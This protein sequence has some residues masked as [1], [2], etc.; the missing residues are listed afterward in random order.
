MKDFFY[1]FFFSFGQLFVWMAELH[2]ACCVSGG[3][4]S[5]R[6]CVRSAF[7]LSC[8]SSGSFFFQG[9]FCR[10]AL[11]RDPTHTAKIHSQIFMKVESKQK[12]CNNPTTDAISTGT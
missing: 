6:L 1:V 8:G 10:E 3:F 12:A 2:V 9:G 4:F 7:L 11:L 5:R